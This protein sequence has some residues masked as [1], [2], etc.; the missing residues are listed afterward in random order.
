MNSSQWD[1]LNRND[2]PL[3]RVGQELRVS[4]DKQFV[5]TICTQHSQLYPRNPIP[6]NGPTTNAALRRAA[7]GLVVKVVKV[8]LADNT[9]KV[10]LPNGQT[11]WFPIGALARPGSLSG[12]FSYICALKNHSLFF[13]FYF[14]FI[15]FENRYG[16]T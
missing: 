9:L 14:F 2:A 16:I 15:I 13:I 12:K 11:T 10:Q 4:P 8:D 5:S 7:L 3:I 6:F 1:F